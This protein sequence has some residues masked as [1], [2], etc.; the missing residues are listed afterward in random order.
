MVIDE[1]KEI[2]LDIVKK[3]NAREGKIAALAR[4]HKNYSRDKFYADAKKLGIIK[5]KSKDKYVIPNHN[6]EGQIGLSENEEP[7]KG[8]SK[9]DDK[10]KDLDINIT[11]KKKKTFEID[12]ELERY[13]RIEAAIKD[14]SINEFVNSTLWKAISSDT[15]KL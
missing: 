3:Y 2:V 6:I 11:G 12:I 7:K 10:L 8:I 15:K 1:R 9:G 5:D 14:I 4:E 13:L